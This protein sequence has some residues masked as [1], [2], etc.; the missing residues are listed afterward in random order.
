MAAKTLPTGGGFVTPADPAR[1]LL[2][3][4]IICA[5]C[6]V[7]GVS[8]PDVGPEIDNYRFGAYTMAVVLGAAFAVEGSAGVRSLNRVDIVAIFALYFLSF[9]EFLHPHVR[10]LYQGYTGNAAFSCRLV[11]TGMAF[12]AIGRHFPLPFTLG[13]GKI[14]LPDLPPRQMFWLCVGLF[15]LSFFWVFLSV[16]FNPF[17]VVH[18]M[19]AGRFVRPWQRERIGGWVSFLTELQ[20]LAHPTAALAGYIFANGRRYGIWNK[21][22]VAAMVAFTLAFFISDGA[23]NRV[24]IYAGVFISAYFVSNKQAASLKI[25][26]L[27]SVAAAALWF[28]SGFM[29]DFRNEGLGTYFSGSTIQAQD[30]RGDFMIDNNLVSIAR[31]AQV[32]PNIYPFQGWDIVL[33]IF[34]KW[35]PRALWPDKPVDWAISMES[36]L[37]LDGSVTLAVTYVG[38]AY[39][40]AGVP[41]VILVSFVLGSLSATW[42]KVGLAARTNLELIYYATGFFAAM[43]GMRS[44]QFITVAFVPLAAFYL[45]A[46]WLGRNTPRP[47]G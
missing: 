30:P 18:Y 28:I 33:Q 38:E 4:A 21:I 45:L 42:N 34:T 2:S 35:V 13:I 12:L 47:A 23:R 39:L 41:T 8:L 6:L 15:F 26:A 31:V 20:L 43:L 44:A 46:R 37:G 22:I 10:V 40:I 19:L 1:T 11:L 9:A 32:F 16:Y 14:R 3:T 5:G 17:E 25:I 29:L 7:T 27:S 24:L 36:A